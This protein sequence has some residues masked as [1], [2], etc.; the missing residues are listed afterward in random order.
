MTTDLTHRAIEQERSKQARKRSEILKEEA[1]RPRDKRAEKQR[2]ETLVTIVACAIGVSQG[3]E[4]KDLCCRYL[5]WTTRDKRSK[6]CM[7]PRRG[8]DVGK[9]IPAVETKD[10][11]CAQSRILPTHT[12]SPAVSCSL[13]WE[14]KPARSSPIESRSFNFVVTF[15]GHANRDLTFFPYSSQS[16]KLATKRKRRP[17]AG[18]N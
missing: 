10:K 8:S 6:W 15:H 2:A 7:I 13:L 16:G 5:R 14:E 18:Q 12:P 3:S 1:R 9:K 17:C 11:L 4:K